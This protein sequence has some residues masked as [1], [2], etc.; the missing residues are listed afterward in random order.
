VSGDMN[1]NTNSQIHNTH[2]FTLSAACFGYLTLAIIRQQRIIK[3]KFFTY[4]CKQFPFRDSV[5]PDDEYI[6]VAETR[7]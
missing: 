3:R 4:L 6:E 7:D 2:F 5:Q 1:I